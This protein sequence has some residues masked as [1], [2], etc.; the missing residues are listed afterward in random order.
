MLYL[1]ISLLLYDII[2]LQFVLKSE[3]G[4][5]EDMKYFSK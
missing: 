2:L 4:E 3:V 5:K 1:L